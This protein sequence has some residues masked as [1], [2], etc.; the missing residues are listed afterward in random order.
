VSPRSPGRP[1]CED[2]RQ[3]ILVAARELL[4]ER[5]LRAVTIEGIAER[6]QTS[7]VTVYRWWSH[8][9]AVVLDAMLAEVSPIMPYRE[10]ASPLESLRDQM[11]S[12]GRF[13][14]GR[15]GQLLAE[16]IAE[17][18]VDKVVGDAYREHWVKPRRADALALLGRAV[19]AGELPAG[20]DLEVTLDALFGPIYHR[21]LVKHAPLSPAFVDDV[22]R[23]V[24]SGVVAPE[25]SRRLRRAATKAAS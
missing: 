8:K 2:T 21:L 9:A 15:R 13:L 11:Q 17:S 5:G 12:F 16:V 20:V 3:R 18:V 10:S 24:M 23:I 7:K 25:A 6:A 1:R 14:R 4:E 19:E 22:F